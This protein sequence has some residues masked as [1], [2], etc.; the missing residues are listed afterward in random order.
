[1]AVNDNIRE[2]LVMAVTSIKGKPVSEKEAMEFALSGYG[3]LCAHIRARFVSELVKG[4][5]GHSVSR[6]YFGVVKSR[7][8]EP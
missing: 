5:I 3:E 1:M 6:G 8:I 2:N 4:K 7:S